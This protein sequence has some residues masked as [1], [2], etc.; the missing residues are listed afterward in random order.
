MTATAPQIRTKTEYEQMIATF[1][2]A[3]KLGSSGTTLSGTPVVVSVPTG[4]T[5]AAPTINSSTI[6]VDGVTHVANTAVQALISGGVVG[7]E[8]VLSCK[9]DGTPSGKFQLLANLTIED[10]PE[11]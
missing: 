11:S 3:V 5:I 2:F 8:Y 4:L 10:D 9:C 7:T 6:T 1:G